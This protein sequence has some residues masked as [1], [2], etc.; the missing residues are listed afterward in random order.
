MAVTDDCKGFV[1]VTFAVL[2]VD[3]VFVDEAAAVVPHSGLVVV[4]GFDAAT[5]TYVVDV[6]D[7]RIVF[8]FHLLLI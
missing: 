6:L 5:A 4:L 7:S 8:A 2:V 1:V 3:V